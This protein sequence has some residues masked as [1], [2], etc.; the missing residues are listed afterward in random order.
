MLYLVNNLKH[1]LITLHGYLRIIPENICKQCKHIYNGH[2]GLINMYPELK[3]K[4]PQEARRHLDALPGR[5]RL[6]VG[7]L[8]YE[9]GA[10]AGRAG[11]GNSRGRSGGS[12]TAA[13]KG[14]DD[15]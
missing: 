2:P 13:R 3:G 1:D 5:R 14:A 12:G 7:V 6:A 15:A 11:T 4:D 10:R 8:P 9:A